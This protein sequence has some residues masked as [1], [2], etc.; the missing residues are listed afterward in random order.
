MQR[1]RP[2]SVNTAH[3]TTLTDQI[4]LSRGHLPRSILWTCHGAQEGSE[5]IGHSRLSKTARRR[6]WS[7]AVYLTRS[8]H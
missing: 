5:W 1:V 4:L 2:A 6:C 8:L 3:E 7:Y